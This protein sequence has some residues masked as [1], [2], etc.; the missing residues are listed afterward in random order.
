MTMTGVDDVSVMQANCGV[1]DSQFLLLC[2][3]QGEASAAIDS[4]IRSKGLKRF[5]LIRQHFG[6]S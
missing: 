5:Y 3:P 6:L 4:I 1:E 2:S